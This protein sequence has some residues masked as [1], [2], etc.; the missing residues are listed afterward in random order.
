MP[1]EAAAADSA[2][3]PPS[4]TP[5]QLRSATATYSAVV[6]ADW[7]LA[8]PAG[9]WMLFSRQLQPGSPQAQL[10]APRQGSAPASSPQSLPALP[11]R[12]AAS[13]LALEAISLPAEAT[14]RCWC[15][16]SC[17]HLHPSDPHRSP[18]SS[19][20]LVGPSTDA[21]SHHHPSV[22]QNKGKTSRRRAGWASPAATTQRSSL[23]AT[24]AALPLVSHGTWRSLSD[25]RGG[26]PAAFQ[27][28]AASATIFH[29]FGHGKS[30]IYRANPDC[31]S[32]MA[33][34]PQ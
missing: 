26:S 18:A 11:Q 25:N 19:E 29:R 15:C 32:L 24:G 14:G 7:G 12:S 2:R 5:L 16:S 30:V 10:A 28:R 1:A 6:L 27:Q 17:L 20:V 3:S 23:S 8:L 4:N 9:G 21:G 13:R 33:F 22:E 31:S 34:L